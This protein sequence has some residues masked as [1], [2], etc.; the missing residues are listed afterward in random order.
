[1][2]LPFTMG[3]TNSYLLHTGAGFILI[4]TGCANRR[5]FFENRLQ[6]AGCRKGDLNLII[7]THGDF[8]HS[9]NAAY[10]RQ[11]FG[12]K[13]AMH[14]DD[15]G[16]VEQRDI[17]FNRRMGNWFSRKV[18]SS[19][20]CFRRSDAFT[21]DVYLED[22]DDLSG[23]G[24]DARIVHIPGHSRG[25]VG[26]YTGS[27]SLFCGDLV[28][29]GSKPFI[30]NLIDDREVAVASVRK[31]KTLPVH[32]VYPGHGKPFPSVSLPDL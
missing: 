26:I 13:I 21:P 27:G 24:L 14:H 23:Y 32:T 16:M 28:V 25:S 1:M 4:D 11:V 5:T 8:D 12:S 30:N 29:N 22:G 10:L 15:S 2:K 19:L 20:F 7:L 31:M 17:F 18:A 6:I 9:G 3:Y